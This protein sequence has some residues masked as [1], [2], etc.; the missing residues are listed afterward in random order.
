MKS[1]KNMYQNFSSNQGPSRHVDFTSGNQNTSG[2]SKKTYKN[3]NKSKYNQ[4]MMNKTR[5]TK[6]LL[7]SNKHSSNHAQTDNS[8][9]LMFNNF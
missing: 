5:S 2:Y 4:R 3:L 1:N 8:K 6:H 7:R 9:H